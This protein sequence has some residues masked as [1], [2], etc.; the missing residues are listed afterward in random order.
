[1][2]G[3]LFAIAADEP[4]SLLV[5]AEE[6]LV[7]VDLS[8]DG[9]PTFSIPYMCSLHNSAVTCLSH[10]TN[11]PDTLWNKLTDVGRQQTAECSQRV[12]DKCCCYTSDRN[13]RLWLVQIA[14]H[15]VS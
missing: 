3:W 7:A 15:G 8:G 6:E 2:I 5:L 11:V 9:W 10:V 13:V 4:H 1:L 12:G 14:S